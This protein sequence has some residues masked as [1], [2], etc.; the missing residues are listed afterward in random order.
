MQYHLADY[1]NKKRKMTPQLKEKNKV[2]LLIKN[3]QTKKS[4][5][6]LNHK[7][8][9]SFFIKV[10]REEISYKLHL[11]LNIKVYLVFHVLLLKSADS[12]TFIQK[13]FHY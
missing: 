6:K 10:V 7:K 2:Y 12:S 8:V 13:T 4:S 5:K 9:E 3:L 1:Q 11:S